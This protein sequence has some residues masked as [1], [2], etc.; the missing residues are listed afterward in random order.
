MNNIKSVYVEI[1]D[2]VTKDYVKKE[3]S[4]F[5]IVLEMMW[6]Y[7]EGHMGD[8]GETRLVGD[9]WQI[10]EKAGYVKAPADY[11]QVVPA[12]LSWIKRLRT[13]SYENNTANEK[14]WGFIF[15]ALDMSS[16]LQKMRD[17]RPL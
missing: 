14:R 16:L 8:G 3:W 6:H 1:W 4:W 5:D 10:L 11:S 7:R 9:I 15:A 12:L 17:A 2:S 13:I